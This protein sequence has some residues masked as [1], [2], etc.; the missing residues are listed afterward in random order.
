MGRAVTG[1]PEPTIGTPFEFALRNGDDC[2]CHIL[3]AQ[4]VPHMKPFRTLR[5]GCLH[6]DQCHGRRQGCFLN[7]CAS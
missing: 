6:Q 3:D 4:V 5:R 7:A 1:S 2:G